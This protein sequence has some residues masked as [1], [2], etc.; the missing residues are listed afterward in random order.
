MPGTLP[1]AADS[2]CCPVGGLRLIHKG[3]RDQRT[4]AETPV[5]LGDPCEWATGQIR[6]SC[7]QQRQ[8]R[9]YAPSGRSL[10]P[11]R[12]RLRRSRRLDVLQVQLGGRGC[13]AG[14]PV[15]RSAVCPDSGRMTTRAEIETHSFECHDEAAHLPPVLTP[16]GYCR[17]WVRSRSRFTPGEFDAVQQTGT[18]QDAVVSC[19]VSARTTCRGC[20]SRRRTS[21]PC[22][23]ADVTGLHRRVTRS[24]PA[25][26][27]ASHLRRH[28]RRRSAPQQLVA[29]DKLAGMA[30][31]PVTGRLRNPRPYGGACSERRAPSKVMATSAVTTS[32]SRRGSI[33]AVGNEC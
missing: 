23:Q 14:W 17:Y 21:R 6:T 13:S 9:R 11:R 22:R 4:L 19:S 31:V 3:F 25:Q 24:G 10:R 2:F 12:S 18:G 30:R 29:Q 8:P 33:V 27:R 15:E 16:A 32:D 26:Y 20:R 7:P 28:L 1:A 5:S